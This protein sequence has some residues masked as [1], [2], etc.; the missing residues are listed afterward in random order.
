MSGVV[1]AA[2]VLGL[3]G[4]ASAAG[5]VS[6]PTAADERPLLLQDVGLSPHPGAR[7]P[8]DAVFRDEAGEAAPLARW[9]EGRPVVLSLVYFGCPMLCGEV[10]N[11][12]TTSLKPI[13]LEAGKDF[14]V[15]TVSFDPHDGPEAARAKKAAVMAHYGRPG[16]APGWHFLT[17]DAEAIRRL[18]DAVGF[19]YTWDAAGAQFAHVAVVAVLTPDGRIARYFPGIEYPARDVRLA[20]VEAS[21]GRIGTVVDRLLLFCYRYDA[22]SGRYTPMIARVVRVSAALTA[23]ALG[24]L[25][26]VLRRQE[27]KPT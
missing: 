7:L 3:V 14:T 24:V 10:L 13:S 21:E 1:L 6:A 20:L 26:V 11:A 4:R 8:L 18:T 2:I 16:A 9:L 27:G 15:L 23:V 22:A 12:L 25:V 17:G 5:G 19:H